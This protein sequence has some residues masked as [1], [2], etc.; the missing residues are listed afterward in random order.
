MNPERNIDVLI[1]GSGIAAFMIA[2]QLSSHLNVQIITK[3][4]HDNS[5]SVR[6]Q[7]GIAAA[8]AKHDSWKNHFEDTMKAGR[9]HNDP[10]QT[11]VLVKK[12]LQI[13]ND[14]ISDGMS[15]DKTL[16]NELAMGMEGAHS[17]PRIL[18]IGG[19]ATGK[20]MMSFLKEEIEKEIP[21]IEDKMVLDLNVENGR[22]IGV[23][24]LNECNKVEHI[25][26][27]H[28]ILATGGCGSLYPYSSNDV[29]LTGDGMALAYRAG[30]GLADLEFIQ[31][32]PTLL[33]KGNKVIGLISEA[34][35]GE[36][37]RLR[38]EN[39]KFL[40]EGIHPLQDLAPRDVVARAIFERIKNGEKVYLDISSIKDFDNRFPTISKMCKDHQL[41]VEKSLLQVTP[42][43]H[44]I[45]GGIVVNNS[46]ETS[47]SGLYAVG[48]TACT[49]VHGANR[50]ASNSLL[51]GVVMAVEC[52][53]TI[54]KSNLSTT[55]IYPK[56]LVHEQQISDLDLPS[57]KEIQEIMMKYVGIVREKR[58]LQQALEWFQPYLQFINT[59]LH[60]VNQEQAEIINMLTV[61]WLITTSSLQ[62]TES[63][64][65]HFRKDIPYEVERW[66]QSRLIRSKDEAVQN[67]LTATGVNL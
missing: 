58:E 5:N 63:R 2:R 43:A 7:G 12:G 46:G 30:V 67:M 56:V 10:L 27:T 8:L 39:G 15:F 50:L 16:N 57:K 36:G 48:E 65:A 24:V 9:F 54:L 55:P 20:G 64:G 42:G 59:P 29:S 49:G 44:F 35:R 21:I 3:G 33:Y 1:V 47:L 26:A 19:D 51:E 40:M 14:L 23:S 34:V 25:Y 62:R 4:K 22:C 37:A 17:L 6:A 31:F 45:M 28:V 60:N 18:H 13:V 52:A 61:G 66:R 11:E 53:D 38:T 32:H 41:I